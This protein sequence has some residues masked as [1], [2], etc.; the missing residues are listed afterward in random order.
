MR[1][2]DEQE[3]RESQL[4]WSKVTTALKRKDHDVAT[5]EKSRIEDQ[6]RVEASQRG[7]AEWEPRLFHKVQGGPGGPEEGEE[8]LDWIINARV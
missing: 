4:L 5:D 3:D 2:L 8:A 1:P 6:Q 7:G